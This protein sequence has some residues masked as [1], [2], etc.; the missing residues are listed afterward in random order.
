MKQESGKV[1][2]AKLARS[3]HRQAELFAQLAEALAEDARICDE[4]ADGAAVDM[5]TM[6]RH[7]ARHRPTLVAPTPEFKAL[8]DAALRESSNRRRAAR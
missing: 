1:Q 2:M 6:K 7:P 5:R 4:L 8:G 3:R